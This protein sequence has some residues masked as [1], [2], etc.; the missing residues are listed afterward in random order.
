M[1]SSS[2]HLLLIEHERASRQTITSNPLAFNS[3]ITRMPTSSDWEPVTATA[4]Q[5]C[6]QNLTLCRS[7][8]PSTATDCAWAS[9]M[10]LLVFC[11]WSHVSPHKITRVGGSG[12]KPVDSASL[13]SG[14]RSFTSHPENGLFELCGVFPVHK[15]S[16][17]RKIDKSQ[18][19]CR[20]PQC[21]Q[22]HFSSLRSVPQ[23]G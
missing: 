18:C 23:T 3:R 9:S 8:S 7:K 17:S 1:Y 20:K 4:T 19:A 11:R 6:L 22:L 14:S 13:L 16:A 21:T 15:K 5:H 12:A 2:W 10:I